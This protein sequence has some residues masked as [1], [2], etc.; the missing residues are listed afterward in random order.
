MS[1]VYQNRKLYGTRSAAL[2]KSVYSRTG[3]SSRKDNVVNDDHVLICDVERDIRS[4]ISAA[5]LAVVAVGRD[6]QSTE[7]DLVLF[8]LRELIGDTLAKRD[9]P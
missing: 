2:Y 3:A 8:K 4:F 7:R 1:A 5:V 9:S 6:I